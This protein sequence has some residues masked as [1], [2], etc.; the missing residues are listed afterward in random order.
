MFLMCESELSSLG[1]SFL[2]LSTTIT[3]FVAATVIIIRV[4]IVFRLVFCIL[5]LYI[6]T[7]MMWVLFTHKKR[8][9]FK[10]PLN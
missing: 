2:K 10:K 6:C 9:I 3:V 5:F 4:I 7:P 1:F 8:A